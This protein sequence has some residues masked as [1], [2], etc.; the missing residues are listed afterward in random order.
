M[1]WLK[2][3]NVYICA[4]MT[5]SYNWLKNYLPVDLTP[6]EI[7]VILTAVG[8]EVEHVEAF[9]KIKGGLKGLVV[10]EVLS[11]VPHPNAEKLKLTQVTTDGTNRLSIVC[12]APNVAQSQKVIVATVGTV[13]YPISGDSFEIKKAKIR[14]EDSEGMLCAEDEIGLG[15][16]HA[17][18]MVLPTETKVGTPAADYFQLPEGDWIFEIGLTP[19][20]MEAMSHMG[21]VKDICA[22]L[23]NRNYVSGSNAR[24]TMNLPAQTPCT[25][26]DKT[27]ITFDV[28]PSICA[29]YS[30]ICIDGIQIKESP[31]WMQQ[32]LKAIGVKPINNI[33]DI[34]NYVLHECGQPLHAFDLRAI[35]GHK[36][37]VQTATEGETFVTLDGKEVTLTANDIMIRNEHNAMCIGGVYGGLYSG[38]KEDTNS[39][40]LESACFDAA[41]IRKTSTHHGLR[42]DAA[43]RFEKGTDISQTIYALQRAMQLI[44]ELAGGEVS[45]ALY[46]IYPVSKEATQIRC[47][48][49]KIRSLAGKNYPSEQIKTILNSLCFSIVSEHDDEFVVAVPFSKPDV[50]MLA[51]V[52]EEIM[53]IDGLDQIPF[54]GK[55]S[56]SIQEQTGYSPDFKQQFKEKLAAKGF[57]EIFT[58]SITNASYYAEKDHLV[59]MMNSLSANLDCMRPSML[60]TGLESIAHN[61]NRKNNQIKFFEFG[62]VYFKKENQYIEQEKLV[63]YVSGNYRLPYYDEKPQPADM[64]Y[65]KGIVESLLQGLKVEFKATTSNVEVSY[66][67]KSLGSIYSVPA[68]LLKT[69]D[70]KQA[71]WYAEL[72]WDVLKIAL[73]QRKVAFTEIPKFPSVQRDLAMIVK[74]ETT[75]ADIQLAVKQAK[76]KL[77]HTMNLFD[78]FTH[79]KIGNDH[80]SYAVNF[81]FYDAAKTLTDV[82]VEAEMKLLI[83]SLE[84]KV[85]ATIRSN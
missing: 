39:L 62:K 57:F 34:T 48:F 55:I 33:V 31:E 84:K 79:E 41:H 24:T 70:I 78:V 81:S 11:C 32:R 4:P 7:S 40:F 44:L 51:D 5:I 52:V 27:A 83:Q 2:L 10:G 85:G 23:N 37:I 22:Y 30:G 76:S 6:D 16:S 54:T 26:S 69:F 68:S 25:S 20:R 14:G 71:V 66:Q 74:K 73:Q 53:R 17:G 50:T 19:N 64:F 18:I 35:A 72:D 58:N 15:E 42:T 65:L 36:I 75:Y 38:I 61:L 63:C 1:N 29:R 56:Y 82:E 12:G 60:E 3:L 21:V 45:S 8:L 46:D 9:E 59:M 13:L 47:S 77:L 80:I 28:D 49:Q 43:L 67:N